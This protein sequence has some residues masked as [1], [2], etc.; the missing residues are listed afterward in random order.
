MTS[1]DVLLV[2]PWS[3]GAHAAWAEGLARHC[4]H[5]IRIVEHEDRFWR[6][7]QRGSAVT[8]AEL[9]AADVAHHGRPDVVVAADFVNLAAFVGLS[10]SWLTDQPVV[11]YLHENQVGYPVL[12]G[13]S[14]EDEAAAVDWVSMQVADAI[15]CNSAF[16][17][18]HLAEHLPAWLAS[19]PDN[20]HRHLLLRT[21]EKFN[22]LPV[23]LELSDLPVLRADRD[24]S[25]PPLI[26]WNQRWAHDKD[27]GRFLRNLVRL[28]DEGV[29][30]DVALAGP[31][32][33][34]DP[35]EFTEA[36]DRL[37][38]RVVHV[39]FLERAAYAELLGRTDVVV[40]T[41]RHEFFGVALL[42][43]IACGAIP[44]LPASLSYPE[45][46]PA[47]YHEAALYGPGR[48]GDRLEQVLLDLPAARARVSGLA[49]AVAELAWPAVADR[50]DRALAELVAG[51]R[52]SAR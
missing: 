36:I 23:G 47:R 51:A 13:R 42:E 9:A 22:V 18:D 50:Y 17:R 39:G 4:S 32:R 35:Q 43:A 37:G 20:D 15:W 19:A 5:R 21:L 46:I 26:T 33:R 7:R 45:V 11:L 30:F 24:D 52:S 16:Q 48:L 28:A 14:I 49:D 40:S 44:V 2:V 38:A 1:L 8:L 12:L 34:S 25:K 3:G 31:N 41:A 10:R 6:W 27:P 29:P